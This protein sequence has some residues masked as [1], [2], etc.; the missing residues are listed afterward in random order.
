ML[1]PAAVEQMSVHERLEAMEL[2][3]QSLA[4]RPEQV[5]SPDW[6]GEVLAERVEE[7]RAGRAKF[8]TLQ[9]VKERFAKKSS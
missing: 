1:S 2:L 4:S 7:I 8:L 5:P 9:E 6:H 3:W